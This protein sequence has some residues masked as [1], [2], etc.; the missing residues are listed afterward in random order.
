M[1]AITPG[2][3][4]FWTPACVSFTKTKVEF[5]IFFLFAYYWIEYF[6]KKTLLAS[7]HISSIAPIKDI[8]LGMDWMV[9]LSYEALIPRTSE[10]D[11]I[12]NRAI[13]DKLKWC[14]T[15][16]PYDWCETETHEWT[17]PCDDSGTEWIA[18]TVNQGISKIVSKPPEVRK[19]QRKILPT[20]FRD[21]YS[22]VHVLI[23]DFKHPIKFCGFNHQVCATLESRVTYHKYN[24]GSKLH[25][26]NRH[27]LSW[28]SKNFCIYHPVWA[29]EQYKTEKLGPRKLEINS[30]SYASTPKN[31]FFF[32]ILLSAFLIR[33]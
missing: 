25:V 2:G 18:T 1:C 6:Y 8:A 23:S 12:W 27:E 5:Y 19:R 15:G 29:S 30:S 13:A 22:P 17:A 4:I 11:F 3:V 16:V 14:R 26:F 10:Y 33:L 20:G 31:L 7:K 9:F 28:L 32:W 21:K 24:H